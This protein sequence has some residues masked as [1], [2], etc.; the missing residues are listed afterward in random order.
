MFFS[1]VA[2]IFK[3]D[4]VN[5]INAHITIYEQK[6]LIGK[7]VQIASPTGLWEDLKI[8]NYKHMIPFISG[9]GIIVLHKDDDTGDFIQ[10]KF[11]FTNWKS[12]R[13]RFPK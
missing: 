12:Q 13:I 9:G 1:L 7:T 4:V 10:E 11:S 5:S 6:H 8:I 3:N 2:G